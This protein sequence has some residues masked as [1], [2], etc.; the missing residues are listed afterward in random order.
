MMESKPPYIVFDKFVFRSPVLSSGS[1]ISNYWKSKVFKD[2]VFLASRNYFDDFS[3][4][5]HEEFFAANFPIQRTAMKYFTRMRSRCT[6]FGLFAGVGVGSIDKECSRSQILLDDELSFQPRARLDMNFICKLILSLSKNSLIRSV[7]N[8]T[9]NNSLYRLR[10]RFR[11]VD[12]DIVN[13][14]RKYHLSEVAYSDYLE[15]ILNLTSSGS[16]VSSL[17]TFLVDEGFGAEEAESYIGNLIDC[18][19]IVDELYPNVTGQD[20]F[21]TVINTLDRL[22]VLEDL[23]GKLVNIQRNLDLI[24]QAK[25]GDCLRIFSAIEEDLASTGVE[26]DRKYIFQVDL[27][28]NPVRAVLD[29]SISASLMLGLGLLNRLTSPYE[30]PLL[31]KFRDDFYRRYEEEEIPLLEALDS[32]IGVGFAS[33]QPGNTDENPLLD[34]IF[35]RNIGNNET[36][37]TRIDQLIID[38]YFKLDH[39][40]NSELIIHDEDLTDYPATWSDLP[41]T[42]GTI[43]EL[44]EDNT[45]QKGR[46][47]VMRG[48]A[49][50]SAANLVSR[51][52]YGNEGIYGLVN[53]VFDRE[54]EAVGEGRIIAEI[55]H[56]PEARTGNI[57]FRSNL[58]NYEIP[59]LAGTG[60]NP[61]GVVSLNDIYVSVPGGKRIVLRSLKLN[62]EIIPRLSNAHAYNNNPLPVYYFLSLLQN[63]GQRSAL[64]FRWPELLANKKVLPR[65]R[66]K[67]LILSP[68]RWSFKH[69][70]LVGDSKNSEADCMSTISRFRAEYG[71]PEKVLLAE[72]DNKLMIDFS[73]ELS[74]RLF[75]AEVKNRNFILEEYFD[76]LP[77]SFISSSSGSFHNQ[78]VVGFYRQP[79]S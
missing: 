77:D 37:V 33:L 27:F 29:D 15:G 59:F 69:H 34:D 30:N 35:F 22:G 60:V 8:Y 44:I 3:K 43:I 16:S 48:V 71:V 67:D 4:V 36:T 41:I 58:R 19:I 7:S 46:S 32:D 64:A 62:K 42:L 14:R 39:A 25:M 20:I 12:F 57:I 24:G 72:G 63:Q 51:F 66:Y 28:V 56:L 9:P 75:F 11:Y 13:G 76:P 68:A 65:V 38:K 45:V 2:A 17:V 74:V 61:D 23:K 26:Y 1:S 53:E 50:S 70:D 54:N 52:S 79:Q 78:F 5:S 47:I 21:I 6:P 40:S 18:Q 31:V 73:D 55:V 49:G 10:D